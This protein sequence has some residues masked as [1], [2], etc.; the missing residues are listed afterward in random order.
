MADHL[1][2]VISADGR[3]F[4]LACVTTNLVAEA[5]RRHDTGPVAAVALGRALTANLLVAALLKDDQ[6]VMM[7]FE[8]NGP[9]GKIITEG[10]CTGEVRGYVAHPHADVPLKNGMIDVA[11]GLGQAGFLTVTKD[12]GVSQNYEG[13]VQLYTSEIGEDVAFYLTESEQ[14]PSAI[15]VGVLVDNSGT[16]LSAGG[17]LVQSLPPADEEL[18]A[19]LET[20]VQKLGSVT[21]LIQQGKTPDDILEGLFGEIPHRTLL[22]Q[23]LRYQCS[24]NEE[25]M[26]QALL[27]LEKDDLIRLKAEKPDGVEVRC[28][29]CA[30]TY[31]F[32][33]VALQ[34]IID[35]MSDGVQ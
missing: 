4:G 9:L 12:I 20:N 7:K 34:S 10:F 11:S 16:I 21:G 8:G 30:N 17:F 2:R 32:D 28:E 25:K 35:G 6:R 24:C 18:I 19:S 3:F 31:V 23:D 22:T 33:G 13:T 15:S 1:Q 27:T 5:C 26:Q 29:F 14:V